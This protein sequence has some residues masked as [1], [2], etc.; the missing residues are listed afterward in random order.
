MPSSSFN[1]FPLAGVLG[2]LSALLF[3]R[4]RVDEG[5]LPA[6][7]TKTLNE[8]L[9]ILRRDR[10]F[11]RYLTSFSVYGA[12]AL[13]AWTLYPIVQVDRLHLTYSQIGLLGLAQSVF[14]LLGFVYWGR[15]VDKRGGLWVLRANTLI[16]LAIPFTYIFANRPGCSCPPL[17]PTASPSPGGIWARSMPQSNWPTKRR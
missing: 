7:Q 12:G 4:L 2:I 9:G 1:V 6:R 13:I 10:P 16:N 8:L 14:W 3:L 5:Q 11:T 17:S 15:Q